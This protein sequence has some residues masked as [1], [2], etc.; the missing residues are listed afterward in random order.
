M[1]LSEATELSGGDLEPVFSCCWYAFVWCTS[2]IQMVFVF[3]CWSQ[4]SCF[5]DVFSSQILAFRT[6]GLSFFVVSKPF[7]IV[8]PFLEADV[9][10]LCFAK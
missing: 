5:L 4:S 6:F 2:R 3:G 9:E 7:E 1:G 10:R 8:F